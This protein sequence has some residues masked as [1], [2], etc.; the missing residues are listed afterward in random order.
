MLVAEGVGLGR[1][2]DKVAAGGGQGGRVDNGIARL[3]DDI[4]QATAMEHIIDEGAGA[5]GHIGEGGAG[6]PDQIGG[7]GAPSPM[8]IAPGGDWVN[9]GERSEIVL[10][11]AGEGLCLPGAVDDVAEATDHG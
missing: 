5:G 3:V 11:L 1:E 7:P 8:A 2:Q 9:G 4:D 10:N 6:A